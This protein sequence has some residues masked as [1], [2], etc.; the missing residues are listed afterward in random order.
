M[1][2]PVFDSYVLHVLERSGSRSDAANCEQITEYVVG[3]WD[4]NMSMVHGG[5]RNEHLGKLRR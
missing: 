1:T 5:M 2:D 4:T 3:D